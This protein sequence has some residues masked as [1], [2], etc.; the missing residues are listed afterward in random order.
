MGRLRERQD[1]IRLRWV[2]QARR[3]RLRSPAALLSDR[4]FSMRSAIPFFVESVLHSA[5]PQS[6]V[7]L[8]L[9]RP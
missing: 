6:D 8:K 1:V 7:T 9:D 4:R 2:G 3:S 5:S